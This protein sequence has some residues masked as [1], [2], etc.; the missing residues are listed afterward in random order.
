M[1]HDSARVFGSEEFTKRRRLIGTACIYVNYRIGFVIVAFVIAVLRDNMLEHFFGVLIIASGTALVLTTV[2]V[3]A[4]HG[5]PTRKAGLATH[6]SL[7][8]TLK[9]HFDAALLKAD[10]RLIATYVETAAYGLAFGQLGS[11]MASFFNEEVFKQGA[12]NIDGLRWAAFSALTSSLINYVLDALLPFIVFRKNASRFTM[13]VLWVFGGAVGTAAFLALKFAVYQVTAL[14]LFAALA[15]TTSTHNL[16]SL[17]AAGAYVEPRLRGTV[18]GVRAAC[19]AT[20]GFI[21]A[22][23]GGAISEATT[24]FDWVMLFCAISVGLSTIAAAFGGAATED[25]VDGVAVNANPLVT[26]VL[27]G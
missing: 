11:V 5:D 17:M 18:F 23:V 6:D 12:A 13:P 10:K 25:A 26:Y 21:G 15:I 2:S 16:F 1:I 19:G 20:G 9:E 8:L 22:F 4:T 24:G 27:S 7:K 14:L 3:L